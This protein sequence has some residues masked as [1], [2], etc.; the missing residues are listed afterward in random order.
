M[1]AP[2][3]ERALLD[4]AA[5]VGVRVRCEPFDP[6]AFPDVDRRGGLCV[7]D[8]AALILIDARLDAIER[9]AILVDALSQLDLDALSMPPAIRDRLAL[10]SDKRADRRRRTIR[11]V[12]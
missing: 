8:G 9:V 1:D 12:K 2:S 5:R 7:V 10:A 3:L 4:L 11:S 6:R